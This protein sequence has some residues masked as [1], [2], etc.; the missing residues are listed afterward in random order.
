MHTLYK[1]YGSYYKNFFVMTIDKK[2]KE[3]IK[4]WDFST[5]EL[6]TLV[7]EYVHFLQNISTTSGLS[8]FIYLSKT[9][10][11]FM[12]KASEMDEIIKCPLS[13]YDIENFD[14]ENDFQSL[15]RGDDKHIVVENIS[16]IT[17]KNE[18]LFEEYHNIDDAPYIAIYHEENKNPYHFGNICIEESMAYLIER[19]KFDA[20]KRKNELPYNACELVIE[21][22]CPSFYIKKNV[23]VALAE[24]SLMHY[25]SGVMFFNMACILEKEKPQIN[26]T[27][28]VY[29]YFKDKV[30]HLY[31]NMESKFEE[32]PSSINFLYPNVP[33]TTF[34]NCNDYLTKIFDVAFKLRKLDTLFISKIM[35]LK[36]N[37]VVEYLNKLFY[38]LG[39]PPLI[40][41]NKDVYSSNELINMLV[42]IAIYEQFN[43]FEKKC[44]MYDICLSQKQK[45][46]DEF[47]CSTEPWKQSQQNELC[48]FAAFLHKYSLAGKIILKKEFE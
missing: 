38:E 28:D 29:M 4:L 40:D 19:E 12:F 2:L 48:P 10:Q 24:I 8:S 18:E 20:E 33:Q 37:D 27:N 46:F 25:N 42:P 44:Y 47:V 35:D 11:G 36:Q 41:N 16:H 26:T 31:K 22:I 15:Y 7:H 32:L 6:A 43:S 17:C 3:N 5:E 23:I 30:P 45:Q 9:I 1:D 21:K 39:I 13:L 14:L 34:A